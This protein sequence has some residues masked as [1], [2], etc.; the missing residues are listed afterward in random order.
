MRFL[1]SKGLVQLDGGDEVSI[2]ALAADPSMFDLLTEAE[3]K[4]L[5]PAC[6]VYVSAVLGERAAVRMDEL[7][8][9]QEK[10]PRRS[11]FISGRTDRQIFGNSLLPR[12]LKHLR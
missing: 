1:D 3:V 12:E 6:R 11:R 10:A 4:E 5:Y 2:P 7:L 9:A 8:E